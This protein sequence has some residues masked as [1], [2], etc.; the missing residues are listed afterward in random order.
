MYWLK[1]VDRVGCAR[2]PMRSNFPR[3]GRCVGC[4]D[5]SFSLPVQPQG[6]LQRRRFHFLNSWPRSRTPWAYLAAKLTPRASVVFRMDFSASPS[7]DELEEPRP[8]SDALQRVAA[9][10]DPH[11]IPQRSIQ[12]PAFIPCSTQHRFGQ[13]T[14]CALRLTPQWLAPILVLAYQVHRLMGMLDCI[15]RL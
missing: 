5:I 3:T 12:S 7:R 10:Y 4:Q 15:G 2:S 1:R 14:Y 11:K 9:I 13:T 6:Y 8:F